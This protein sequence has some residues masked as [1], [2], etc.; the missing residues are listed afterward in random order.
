MLDD[1]NP[2]AKL[3]H[4]TR[5]Y[6]W[7]NLTT[8]GKLILQSSGSGINPRRYSVPTGGDVATII[9]A[10]NDECPLNKNIIIYK[11]RED[12]GQNKSLLSI[13][14]KQPMYDL[15]LYVLMFP[16]GDKGWEL[17]CKPGQREYYAYRLM[18][19]SGSTF[20]IVHRMGC[21]FQQYVVDMYSKV[22]ASWLWFIR[23]NQPK[24]H[25]ELTVV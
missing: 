5:D 11:K 6:L 21:L 12:H 15:L 7:L 20:N 2:Y 9:P 4:S 24:L 17:K 16:Y 23:N 1:V 10:D 18:L 13:D 14:D 8:D 25:A 22:E 3:Y 19:H